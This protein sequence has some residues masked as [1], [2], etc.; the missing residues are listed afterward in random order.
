MRLEYQ[1]NAS[2]GCPEAQG[3]VDR[4][5][6]RLGY[7][8]FVA[9]SERVLRLI[10]EP[11]SDGPAAVVD[12]MGGRREIPAEQRGCDA[13]LDSVASVIALLID[14]LALPPGA[15]PDSETTDI[16][17]RPAPPERPVHSDPPSIGHQAIAPAETDDLQLFIAV[18]GLTAW[19]MV[20]GLGLGGALEVGM[21]ASPTFSF[22]LRARLV[23]QVSEVDSNLGRAADL[24][25]SSYSLGVLP[26]L[27]TGSLG[28]CAVLELGAVQG[29]G[30]Q[31]TSPSPDATVSLAMGARATVELGL[32]ET[33]ALTGALEVD[34]PIVATAMVVNEET[35]WSSP[36]LNGALSLGVLVHTP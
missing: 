1:P 25:A 16:V 27:H 36:F 31:V 6:A 33:F 30:Q 34:V 26:C 15:A 21:S 8:P 4:I 23:T 2:L 5:I 17:L 14:P 35:V 12:L 9:E 24:H 20:P 7:S 18:H 13:L 3:L 28:L 32:D 29:D 10:I 19:G 11:S 22:A